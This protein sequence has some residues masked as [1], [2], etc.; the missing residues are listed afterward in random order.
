MTI[1]TE[2]KTVLRGSRERRSALVWCPACRREV[3]MVT[4]DQAAQIASASERTIYRWVEGGQ[5]HFSEARE[6]ALLICSDSLNTSA[7]E[8][9]MEIPSIRFRAGRPNG[10]LG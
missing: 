2:E 5:L 3:E 10:R 8:V 9:K 1:E 4:P 6:G 7:R